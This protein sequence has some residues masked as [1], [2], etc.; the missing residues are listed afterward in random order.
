MKGL[1]LDKIKRWSAYVVGGTLGIALLL[2]GGIVVD[3]FFEYVLEV[4]AIIGRL[5]GVT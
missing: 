5:I 4:P 3:V 2:A 1:P